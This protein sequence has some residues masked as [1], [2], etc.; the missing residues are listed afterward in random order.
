MVVVR[1]PE[2]RKKKMLKRQNNPKRQG[3]DSIQKKR[4]KIPGNAS[5]QSLGEGWHIETELGEAEA[6]ELEAMMGVSAY[7]EA[8]NKKRDNRG[9]PKSWRIPGSGSP[10]TETREAEGGDKEESQ[11]EDE[12]EYTDETGEEGSGEESEASN[13]ESS[14]NRGER[15]QQ[16]E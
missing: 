12:G 13:V 4:G 15:T 10:A 3:Y 8:T 1:H 16:T 5:T 14:R 2:K 9:Y 11:N 6:V 7:E